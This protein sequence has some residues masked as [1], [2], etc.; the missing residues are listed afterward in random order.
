MSVRF[1]ARCFGA[2]LIAGLGFLPDAQAQQQPSAATVALAAK[3]LE[4]KGGVTAFDPAVD[5]VV[6]HHKSVFLQMNP[7]AAKDLNELEAKFRAEGAARRQELHTEVAR[8]YAAQFNEQELKDLLTFF[9]T[10]LGK[11][12]ID[13]E[14]KAGEEAAKRVQVWVD[15]YADDVSAKMRAELKRK[16][17]T[18]F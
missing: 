11:K 3:V 14:P 12:L 6:A 9:S 8:A 1:V 18:E 2:V 7:N 5:G 17:F 13:A 15:K 4:L 16:G 10:P